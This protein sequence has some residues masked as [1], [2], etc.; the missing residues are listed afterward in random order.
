MSSATRS[1]ARAI[2]RPGNSEK[3]KAA[4]RAVDR[5]QREYRALGR[6]VHAVGQLVQA[7]R[8]GEHGTDPGA[9]LRALLEGSEA[10]LG[11]KWTGNGLFD[12][13]GKLEAIQ[14]PAPVD[15]EEIAPASS[16]VH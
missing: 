16:M 14:G 15:A 10:A 6:A 7:V 3:E 4:R 1:L 5:L 11:G 12:P 9:A 8:H 2:T 13:A